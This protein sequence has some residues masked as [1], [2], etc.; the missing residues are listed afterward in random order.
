MFHET[1]K[2]LFQA[3]EIAKRGSV[4]EVLKELRKL[5]LGD[6]GRWMWSLPDAHFSAISALL[7]A[8]ASD[9]AQLGWTGKCGPE[10]RDHT[11]DFVRIVAQNFQRITGRSLE[12]KRILDFGFGYGRI[13]RMMYYFTDPDGYFGVDP[14]Q[15]SLDICASDRVLGQFKKINYITPDFELDGRRFDLIFAYSVFTHTSEKVT[16][17]SLRALRRHIKNNGVLVIT[18]RPVEHWN[19]DQPHDE[20]QREAFKHTHH[21][22]GFAFRDHGYAEDGEAIYGENS[23]TLEWLAANHP[24]WEIE[25]WD[26]G[27]DPYQTIVFLTPK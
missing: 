20:A 3:E 14:M 22:K 27:V 16:N 19:V 24:E 15:Q 18:I 1:H 6:F 21:E 12:H 8:M 11:I 17:T 13:A 5:S 10:L 9:E 2:I 25:G 23:F 7:P 4:F 26:R